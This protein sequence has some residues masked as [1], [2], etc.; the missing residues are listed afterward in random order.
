[1][2]E[3]FSTQPITIRPRRARQGKR[4]PRGLRVI[5]TRRVVSNHSD[6]RSSETSKPAYGAYTVIKRENKD[7]YWLNIGVLRCTRR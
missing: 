5:S 1:V 2:H 3:T 4:L 7:D 6:K